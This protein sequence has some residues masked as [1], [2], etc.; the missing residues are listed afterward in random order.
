[1]Y[2]PDNPKMRYKREWPDVWQIVA[3]I[4]AFL[5]ASAIVALVMVLA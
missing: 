1:M 3:S 5:A 2:F 4:A